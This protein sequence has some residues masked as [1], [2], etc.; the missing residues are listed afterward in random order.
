MACDIYLPL[1]FEGVLEVEDRNVGS[2]FA[3]LEALEDLREELDID[4]E[5][6]EDDEEDMEL[7]LEVIE[8][9]LA[10]SWRAFMRAATRCI[11]QQIPLHVLQ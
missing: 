11:D 4:D 3:L 2:A 9:N 7:E 6:G 8:E 1:E 5:P 10:Y